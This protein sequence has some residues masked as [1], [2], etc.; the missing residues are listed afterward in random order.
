M[1]ISIKTIVDGSYN[2]KSIFLE[3]ETDFS[4][5]ILLSLKLR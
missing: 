3:I 5:L 4:L 2:E 1:Y